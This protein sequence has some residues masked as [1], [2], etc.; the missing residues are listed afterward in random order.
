MRFFSS[1]VVLRKA[2]LKPCLT[3]RGKQ[4]ALLPAPTASPRAAPRHLAANNTRHLANGL[5]K[6]DS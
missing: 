4:M 2:G 5:R 6:W 1:K 3:E